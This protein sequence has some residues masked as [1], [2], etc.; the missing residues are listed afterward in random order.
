MRG[1]PPEDDMFGISIFYD[2]AERDKVVAEL[3]GSKN[4]SLFKIGQYFIIYKFMDDIEGSNGT[5]LIEPT[6]Q[7]YAA[8]PGEFSVPLKSK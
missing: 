6:A 1:T 4:S 7:D 3:R 8:F 5:V 2:V